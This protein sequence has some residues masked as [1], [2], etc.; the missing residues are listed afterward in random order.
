MQRIVVA[1]RNPVKVNAAHE[2]FTTM[3]P[4]RLYTV[5]GV[6][7][8]SGVSDQPMSDAETLEG[9]SNRVS[10]AAALVPSADYWVGIEGGVE[11]RDRQLAVFAWVIVRSPGGEGRGRSATFFLPDRMTQ[12][13]REGTEMGEAN[14]I[15]FERSDVRS[16]NGAVGVLTGD[17]VTRTSFYVQTVV[18]ALIPFRRPDLYPSA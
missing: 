3:F 6:S 18:L 4:G 13:I 5:E 11:E 9:A 2:A 8:P 17:V 14:D 12:L 10:G 1:S 7:V 16:K 15:V